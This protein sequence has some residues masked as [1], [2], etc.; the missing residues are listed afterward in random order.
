V[1]QNKLPNWAR[2]E[3]RNHRVIGASVNASSY[4]QYAY[5]SQN[6]RIFASPFASGAQYAPVIYFYGVDGQQLG[7]FAGGTC[8]LET[9]FYLGSKR[10]GYTGGE[11]CG[12]YYTD[13]APFGTP[14]EADRLGSYGTYYPWGEAKGSTNPADIWSFGTYWRDSFTGLD[15][16]N[17]RYYSSVLAR[18]MTPDPYKASSGP[19]DPGSWNRYTYTRGDPVNRTDRYGTCDDE[20]DCDPCSLDPGN[21]LCSPAPFQPP[22]PAPP[23]VT[24]TCG[25]T[26]FSQ[27][28]GVDSSLAPKHTYLELTFDVNVGGVDL[29]TNTYIEGLPVNKQTGAIDDNPVTAGIPNN[30]WLNVV[31]EPAHRYNNTPSTEIWSTGNNLTDCP[32][33]FGTGLFAGSFPNNT[34]GYNAEFG[35]NSNTITSALLAYYALPLLPPSQQ[36]GL[37]STLTQLNGDLRYVGWGA[38][39]PPWPLS[40]P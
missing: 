29:V 26:L 35:Y 16:A 5:D 30:D 11:S 8:T 17:Q 7:A 4:V 34:Y 21:P 36:P 14:I 22:A 10:V 38:P 24:I 15:Y 13:P 23:V 33:M 18:F 9:S 31:A 12:A 3:Y 37:L 20:G 27:P 40:L 28:I 6:K 32:A 2:I 39:I 25:V 1:G 19:K